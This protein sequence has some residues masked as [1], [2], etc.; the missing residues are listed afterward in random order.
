MGTRSSH[1]RR[2]NS[3]GSIVLA[4]GTSH[5]RASSMPRAERFKKAAFVLLSTIIAG[6]ACGSSDD[7]AGKTPDEAGVRDAD[8]EMDLDAAAADA[9]GARD[10]PLPISD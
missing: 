5:A 8:M 3:R 6:A 4:H 2:F 9:D 7:R 1:I 10:A